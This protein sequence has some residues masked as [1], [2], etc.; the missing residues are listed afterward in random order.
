MEATDEPAVAYPPSCGGPQ[1]GA[2]VRAVGLGDADIPVPV[3]PGDDLGAHPGLAN[4]PGLL[5]RPAARD[6]VPAL[7]EGVERGGRVLG[8]LTL[9][10]HL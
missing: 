2:Q 9:D 10:W 4:D 7:G 8:L 1:V 6:E 3:I 5:Q